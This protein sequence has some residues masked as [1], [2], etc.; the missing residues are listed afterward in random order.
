MKRHAAWLPLVLLLALQATGDEPTREGGWTLVRDEASGVQTQTMEMTLTPRAEPRPALKYQLLPDAFDMLD[1]NAAIYYL[2]AMGFLEQ[3][4]AHNALQEFHKAA[5]ERA[6]RENTQWSEVPPGVW[7]SMKPEELPLEEVKKYLVFTS[8]QPRFLEE[9]V[10]RDRFN[11]DRHFREEEDPIA[12]L[13]PEIQAMREL[14]RTQSLRCKVAIAEGRL[15]EALAILG[16][17]YALARHLGQ[18]EFLVSNL[19]GIA[20]A[21]IAWSDFLYLMQ[22]PDAPNYYWAVAALPR[23]LLDM[24]YS[25]AVERRFLYLQLKVLREV[26]ETPRPAGY[27]QDFLD[28]LV[29]QLGYL[30]Q[31]LGLPAENPEATRAMLVGYIAAAYPGAKRCLIEECGLP[32]EQVEAYPTAQV[33]FLA[34]VRFAD[35]AWDESFKWTLL[36]YWQAEASSKRRSDE[37]GFRTKWDRVGF[38][39]A[40]PG[41]LLPAIHAARMAGSRAEQQLC[42]IQTVEAIRIYG[43]ANAGKLPATLD[44]LPVPAPLDPATGKLLEYQLEGDRATLTGHEWPGLRYRLVL[45][46]R[47]ETPKTEN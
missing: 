5:E 35:E 39:G 20:C 10:R 46:F 2:K 14:A 31:N 30:A 8:F 44:E 13:L 1:G 37:E 28:R 43:A 32:R 18:D 38:A 9:A 4:A 36:P 33:V 42:L 3:Q 24:R 47:T 34:I 21:G 26:D 15:D 27:W 7:F 17:Q 41:M 29:P 16:Q 45:R 19:V 25:L 12:Y 23:P 6:N 40:L 22:H 11:M